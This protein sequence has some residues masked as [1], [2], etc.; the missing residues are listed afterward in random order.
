MLR[1]HCEVPE[2]R[3]TRRLGPGRVWG[4]AGSCA[5]QSFGDHCVRETPGS[6]P[7]P[8]VKPFSADGTARGTVWETRTSPDNTPPQGQPHL[9]VDPEVFSRPPTNTHSPTHHVRSAL[10]HCRPV[11]HPS[12]VGGGPPP[13]PL[14]VRRPPDTGHTKTGGDYRLSAA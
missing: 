14:G 12:L 10:P 8:E 6:I 13:R 3:A 2:T 9:L 11:P 4:G 5:R 7:N 1:V